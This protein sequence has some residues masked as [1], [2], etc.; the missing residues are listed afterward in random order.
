ME[1]KGLKDAFNSLKGSYK[2]FNKAVGKA[3]MPF[4][5]PGQKTIRK[6]K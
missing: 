4:L 1:D 2:K 6:K 3:S 5:R